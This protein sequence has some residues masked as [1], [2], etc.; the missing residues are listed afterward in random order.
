MLRGME[1][2]QKPKLKQVVWAK[3]TIGFLMNI[4]IA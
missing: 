4:D 2:N 1:F 3:V